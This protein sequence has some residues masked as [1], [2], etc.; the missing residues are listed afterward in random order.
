M[1]LESP[2]A[3]LC[4]WALAGIL[5][6]VLVHGGLAGQPPAD[7]DTPI[8]LVTKKPKRS[9]TLSTI[10][11]KPSKREQ[12]FF[13]MYGKASAGAADVPPRIEAD[14]VRN[15]H[16]GTFTF[17]AAHG[18]QRG[19]DQ[20]R[21]LNQVDLDDIYDPYPDDDYYKERPGNRPDEEARAKAP[22]ESFRTSALQAAAA[23]KAGALAAVADAASF[24]EWRKVF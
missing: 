3:F 1:I 4:R 13:E 21:K 14:Y 15:W 11:Y 18:T 20:W 16:W 17:L 2:T 19:S 8:E 22:P 10:H 7:D 12:P 23:A 5:L 24:G 6:A 9:D